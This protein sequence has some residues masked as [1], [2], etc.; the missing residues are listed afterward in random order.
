MSISSKSL[1]TKPKK[2]FP[3]IFF[4]PSKRYCLIFL[5][6]NFFFSPKPII[7]KSI[8]FFLLTSVIEIFSDAF[9]VNLFFLI[10]VSASF[11]LSL[12]K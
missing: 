3:V 4:K 9:A 8:S 11:L 12:S 6:F 1:S 2:T 10:I 5:A 7:I